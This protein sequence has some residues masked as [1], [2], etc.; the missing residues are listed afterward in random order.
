MQGILITQGFFSNSSVYL[1]LIIFCQKESIIGYL[2]V[3]SYFPMW[4]W[5]F[6]H[7]RPYSIFVV[8]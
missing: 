2:V 7:L 1:F 4:H 3:Q 6:L 5:G 8:P